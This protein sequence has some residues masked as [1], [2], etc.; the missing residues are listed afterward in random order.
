M[1]DSRA[2]A[3][4]AESGLHALD[5]CACGGLVHH[6]NF[7]ALLRSWCEL[8]G[9]CFAVSRNSLLKHWG[10]EIEKYIDFL[11]LQAHPQNALQI[12]HIEPLCT[13]GKFLRDNGFRSY[14]GLL[15]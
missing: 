3:E 4:S 1:S 13:L 7:R 10:V 8:Q 6:R 14:V 9:G 15:I 11:D 5:T 2:S 12:R